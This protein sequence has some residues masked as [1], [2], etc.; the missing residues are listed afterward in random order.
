MPTGQQVFVNTTHENSTCL[1]KDNVQYVQEHCM[2]PTM[3]Y[4]DITNL[5]PKMVRGQSR[6][7]LKDIYHEETVNSVG[8]SAKRIF[9]PARESSM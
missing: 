3:V 9:S 1:F 8:V 2:K 4:F 7:L 5:N 6:I